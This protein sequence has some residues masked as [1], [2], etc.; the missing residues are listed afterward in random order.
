MRTNFTSAGYVKRTPEEIKNALASY[1]TQNNPSYGDYT[2]D[3]QNNLLD[4]SVAKIS[5]IENICAGIANSFS[6]A[7][8]GCNDFIWEQQ[9]A[10]LGLKYKDESKSKVLLKFTG[11]A[12]LY[13]PQETEVSNG[14]KTDSSLTLDSTGVG[15]VTATSEEDAIFAKGTINEI[16]TLISDELTVTN[17]SSSIAFQ[18]EETNKELKLRAQRLL[19]SPRKGS[20]DYALNKLTEIE[21]VQERLVNFS[22]EATTLNRGIEVIVAGGNSNEVATAIF[23]SFFDIGNIVSAPSNN[24]NDR[25]S[26]FQINYFGSPI[27]IKWTIPKEL[28]LKIE[29]EVSFRYVNVY[30]GTLEQQCQNAFANILNTRRVGLPL[31][32]NLLNSLMYT[33]IKRLGI[34]LQYLASINYVIYDAEDDS[35]VS[36]D[37]TGYV[38]GVK[39]DIYTTLSEF[40]LTVKAST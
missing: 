11:P 17:P 4:T 28:K 19:R 8:D 26:T 29:V 23:D 3:I 18:P 20:L 12:G 25:T 38:S 22:F 36:F 40:K 5:E 39:K 35:M 7:F 10:T 13:I 34:D 21:G 31:N 27:D 24:E 33:E 9:A 30:S 6:P 37:G 2:S 32:R 1:M 15:T 16:K 14:F